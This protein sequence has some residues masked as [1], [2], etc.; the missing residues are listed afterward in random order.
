MIFWYSI[1]RNK[2]EEKESIT[3]SN[4]KTKSRKRNGNS[5][6]VDGSQKVSSI[7][8]NQKKE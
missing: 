7:N 1:I 3:Y 2:P 5:D 4:N 6:N 8:S